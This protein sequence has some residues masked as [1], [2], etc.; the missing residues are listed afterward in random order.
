MLL[1]LIAFFTGEV[2][3][4]IINNDPVLSG[5][6]REAIE[7]NPELASWSARIEAADERIP[8]VGA[9]TDPMLSLGL[10]NL[11]ANTLD[12][13]REPMTAFWITASQTVPITGKYALKKDI[14]IKES[15]KESYNLQSRELAIAEAVAHLWYKWAYYEA[16]LT[17]A[18]QTI[19]LLDDILRAAEKRYETGR[20]LQSDLLR[21]ATEKT[22][23][24]DKRELHRQMIKTT[25]RRIAVLLGR[26][27][28][29]IP[30]PPDS[31]PESFAPLMPESLEAR[32]LSESPYLKTVKARLAISE[33]R[34]EL[35]RRLWWPEVKLSAGYG[36]RQEADNGMNRPDFLTVTAGVSLP[37]FGAN[38]Q[39]RAVEEARAS[40]YGAEA[41]LRSAELQFKLQLALLLDEEE[42][43]V[44]QIELY[45]QGVEPQA[46]TSLSAIMAAY[47]AGKT[48]I[49]ALLMAEK[50]LLEARLD[51]MARLRDRA[52]N[53]ASIAS[54]VGGDILIEKKILLNR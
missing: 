42:R 21:I 33:S 41:D 44:R 46:E 13:N 52:K 5:L 32:M 38:K 29:E 18:N 37:V 43:L 25:G 53:R 34:V 28:D 27:P 12:F 7:N 50:V 24:E 31:L 35:T 4:Q 9:W 19:D 36:F 3:S 10:M 40:L 48:D 22:K 51:K 47:S 11:P 39:G 14:A 54:L 26:A 16:A 45:T 2:H 49:D 23:M 15:E 6:I 30:N 8:Q 1:G 17:T 20:G